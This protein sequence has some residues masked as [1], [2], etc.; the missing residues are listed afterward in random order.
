M[1]V[2][3]GVEEVDTVVLETLA[4]RLPID[5][6]RRLLERA[7]LCKRVPNQ[8]TI[9][10]LKEANDIARLKLYDSFAELRERI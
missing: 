5:S 7:G 4:M 3:H 9:E 6:I 10:A 8:A 1:T 2:W